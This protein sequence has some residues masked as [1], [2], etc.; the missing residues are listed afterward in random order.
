MSCCGGSCG[1]GENAHMGG[2]EEKIILPDID[3]LVREVARGKAKIC[4][5]CDSA[6]LAVVP[7]PMQP[8]RDISI[9][10]TECGTEEA[11][12]YLPLCWCGAT[13]RPRDKYCHYQKHAVCS[14][15]DKAACPGWHDYTEKFAEK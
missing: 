6:Y 14:C 4:P 9:Y 1:C 12:A 8:L 10:C 7:V 3:K 15:T 13:I 2:C 11:W 5:Q